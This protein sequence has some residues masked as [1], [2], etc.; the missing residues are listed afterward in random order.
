MSKVSIHKNLQQRNIWATTRSILETDIYKRKRSGKKSKSH[1]NLFVK[2]LNGFE[3]GLKV[4]G[5]YEKGIENAKNVKVHTVKLYFP[6]LPPAFEGYRILHLSDLHIDSIPDFDRILIDKIKDLEY[7]L[8]V[9]TGDYRKSTA[10]GFKGI[11]RPMYRLSRYLRPK[12]TT[13]AI[14]GNHDTYLMSNYEEQLNVNM[15][16]NENAVI[17]RGKEK[18]M[19][20]GTDDPFRYYTD[21]AIAALE[22]TNG[23]FKI[24]LIHTAELIDIAEANHYDLYL[25]GHTHGGQICLP[26]GKPLITHQFE[27]NNF[28]SGQW[29]YKSMTGYTSLGCGVSGLPV[30]FNSTGEIALIELHRS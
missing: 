15:L 22:S 28:Y 13:L 17:E 29:K 9:L 18:I 25:C 12:D 7:D 2:L 6:N 1:W 3:F 14:L 26:N 23:D 21:Q 30:R 11:M 27:G 19:I 20:T 10:G 24:A 5:L 8:C 4:L 16:I